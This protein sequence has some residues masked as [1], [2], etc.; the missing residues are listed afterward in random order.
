MWIWTNSH[1]IVASGVVCRYELV[2]NRP[3]VT[4]TEG[5]DTHHRITLTLKDLDAVDG[6]IA[7]LT[8]GRKELA[9]TRKEQA[10]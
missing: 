8:K 2:C 9:P 4:L 1:L 7:A 6:L 5:D 3:F 10:A